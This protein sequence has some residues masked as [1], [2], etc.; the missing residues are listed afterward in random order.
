M[1]DTERFSFTYSDYNELLDC[2]VDS[3]YSFSF[4]EENNNDENVVF[5]NMMLIN[6][7]KKHLR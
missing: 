1:E 6:L 4:F 7:S 3:G 2:I 5:L